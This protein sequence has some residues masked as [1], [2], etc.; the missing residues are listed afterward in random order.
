M[1]DLILTP[2]AQ[3]DRDEFDWRYDG[4]NCSCHISAPCSS[5]TH[6]G[7]PQNQEDDPECWMEATND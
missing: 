4:G 6:P 1:T 2:A 7:N 5:C 3:A